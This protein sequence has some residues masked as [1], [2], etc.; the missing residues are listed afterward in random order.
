[1]T[2]AELAQSVGHTAHGYLSEIETGKKKPSVELVL[3]ISR[4]FNVTT[5]ELLKDELELHSETT[6]D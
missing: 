3:S 4:L 5:D 6:G 2:L 1:M